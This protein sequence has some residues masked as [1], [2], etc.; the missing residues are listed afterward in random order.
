MQTASSQQASEL[1]I[2]ELVEQTMA[3]TS[4]LAQKQIALLR[5][6]LTEAIAMER[7]R[8]IELGFGML[9]ALLGLVMLLVAAVLGLG[10]LF[11]HAE[12]FALALGVASAIAGAALIPI[13]LRKQ[14]EL[15][16]S[17]RRIAEE[18]IQWAKQQ[19]SETKS[20]TSPK[21]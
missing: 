13:S 9:C 4:E 2:A 10:R 15:L 3:T 12:L 11:G 20:L 5:A 6:E 8:A 16:A 21:T 17:S 1:S 19:V 18:E 14:D 7:R